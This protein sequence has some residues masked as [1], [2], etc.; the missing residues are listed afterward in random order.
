[1]TGVRH[2]ADDEDTATVGRTETGGV[3]AGR[4]LRGGTRSVLV[5]FRVGTTA[6][7]ERHATALALA[8]PGT[9]LSY[10]QKGRD[11]NQQD[12]NSR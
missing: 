7:P 2:G 9:R 6:A 5:G 1:M 11:D 12:Q 3:A 4:C 8:L 10:R